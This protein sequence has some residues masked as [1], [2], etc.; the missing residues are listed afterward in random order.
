MNRYLLV[1]E[2]PNDEAIER[3][4]SAYA[5]NST[6]QMNDMALFIRTE[7]SSLDVART[8]GVRGE[9]RVEGASGVVFRIP[10]GWAGYADQDLWKWLRRKDG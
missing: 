6:Y 9:D 3:A 10:G 2:D 1:L 7:D 4:K 5:D 8:C